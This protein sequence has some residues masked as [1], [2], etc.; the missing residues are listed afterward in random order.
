M[1]GLYKR[2]DSPY[3]WYTTGDGPFR[4]RKSTKVKDKRVAQRIADRWN[5]ERALSE[6]GIVIQSIK[7]EKAKHKY[8]QEITAYK[9]ASWAT[10]ITSSLNMLLHYCP[11]IHTKQV[12]S[13]KLQDYFTFRA[14][15]GIAPKTRKEDY[16]IINRFCLWMMAMNYIFSN[17]CDNLVTPKVIPKKIRQAYSDSDIITLLNNA[18]MEKDKRF[19]E[20]L[21]K[22]GLRATD[23]C[24]L[25]IDDIQGRYIKKIQQ[26]TGTP[27]II[28]LHKDLQ[29]K[30]IYNIMHPGSIGRSRQRLKE[31]LPNG[32]LHTFRH[33]FATRIEELGA[34]RWDTKCLLGHKANDVTAQYVRVNI[35]RLADLIDQL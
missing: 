26:K 11:D 35:N 7:L 34:T 20:I 12:T 27:V 15:Q 25:S 31:I 32:D 29:S 10:R 28:P 22:T 23:A 18:R 3:W 19:W 6:H 5:Q 2:D 30:D 4:I 8:I 1:S 17:P 16:K 33:T 13:L 24:T 9:G 21:Y 14:N